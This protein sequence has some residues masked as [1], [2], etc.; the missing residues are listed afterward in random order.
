MATRKKTEAEI[1]RLSPKQAASRY[2]LELQEDAARGWERVKFWASQGHLADGDAWQ[3]FQREFLETNHDAY[4]KTSERAESGFV[5]NAAGRKVKSRMGLNLRPMM[6]YGDALL[7]KPVQDKLAATG[8][9]V[10]SPAYSIINRLTKAAADEGHTKPDNRLSKTNAV[11][12]FQGIIDGWHQSPSEA[13][14]KNHQGEKAMQKKATNAVK[15]VT[16]KDS[17]DFAAAAVLAFMGKLP[18]DA[19]RKTTRG[20]LEK[21]AKE[22]SAI[23]C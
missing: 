14:T 1:A 10:T 19:K 20:R 5:P 15:T 4:M 13:P 8:D 17:R 2:A 18:D 12:F 22:I 6:L 3:E 21:M 7:S 9:S 23:E 11:K 16:V